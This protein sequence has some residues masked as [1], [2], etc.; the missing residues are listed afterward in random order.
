MTLQQAAW[1]L[2]K[3]RS[4]VDKTFGKS[5][6]DYHTHIGRSDARLGDIASVQDVDGPGAWLWQI[7]KGRFV[8]RMVCRAL[9]LVSFRI[10]ES[11]FL[12]FR[13]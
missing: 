1:L 11:R 5:E 7:V 2:F 6:K 12:S 8:C 13:L 9:C 4:L 10:G 3:N